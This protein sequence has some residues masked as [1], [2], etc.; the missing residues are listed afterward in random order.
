MSAVTELSNE[1]RHALARKL[2]EEAGQFRSGQAGSG[3]RKRESS[4]TSKSEE[5]VP[6]PIL[7]P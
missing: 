5:Q 4:S 6:E 3:K 1:E 7:R 2:L